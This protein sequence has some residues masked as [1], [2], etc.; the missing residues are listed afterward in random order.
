M[1]ARLARCVVFAGTLAGLFCAEASAQRVA[2]FDFELIDTSLE[3]EARGTRADEQARLVHVSEQLRLR[4]AGSGR[5]TVVD[6]APVASEAKAQNLQ[7]CGGCDVDLAKRAGADLAVTGTVQRVSNLIL[8]MT[9]YVRDASS[10]A[11][12]AVMNADMRGNT[13]ESWSRTLDWLVRN[14]LLAPDYGARR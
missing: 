7:S 4:L 5:F 11:T 6:I 2:V 1:I 14:R 13:D 3:G 8:N 12:V 9:I 10:S